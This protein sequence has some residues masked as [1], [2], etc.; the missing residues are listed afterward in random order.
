MTTV[1]Q[2]IARACRGRITR[3]VIGLALIAVS[4]L[5]GYRYLYNFFAGPF[6]ADSAALIAAG[7]PDDLLR[8]Y[9]TL[10]VDKTY[11]TG[12]YLEEKTDGIV[13]GRSNY[14]VVPVGG[15]LLLVQTPSRSIGTTI[16]GHLEQPRPDVKQ[17]V[18]A[19]IEGR[20]PNLSGA[21]LPMQLTDDDFMGPGYG[22]LI[23]VPLLVGWLLWTLVSALI[24]AGD[25]L[26]HPIARDLGRFGDARLA[27]SSIDAELA[28]DHAWVENLH[29]TPTWL[30]HQVRGTLRATRHE[31]IVWIYKTVKTYR[32]Y[33][34]RVGKR[35]TARICDRHG[36]VIDIWKRQEGPVNQMLAAAAQRAPWAIMG[37][38]PETERA[39]KRSRATV[40]AG[41]DQRL[42]Q[43]RTR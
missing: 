40:V 6:P 4:L 25:P 17:E 23:I 39:W 30:I 1:G 24:W 35:Y 13:T 31:D 9:L 12:F 14:F 37:Y 32:A 16:T 21:F 43:L 33:G 41:V 8:Y 20:Y 11:D 7:R 42:Q 15:R 10:E 5:A 29:L 22:L 2:T 36:K 34:I 27:I 28:A 26:R 18:I 38:K 19:D 3:A